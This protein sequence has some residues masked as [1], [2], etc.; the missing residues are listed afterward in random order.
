MSEPGR[1]DLITRAGRRSLAG[2]EI[3]YAFEVMA[4]RPSRVTIQ[5]FMTCLI[6]LAILLWAGRDVG[7]DVARRWVA[8]RRQAARHAREAT[9]LSPSAAQSGWFRDRVADHNCMAWRYRRALWLPWEFYSLGESIP[10]GD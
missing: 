4:M 10:P 2:A 8:C 9:R 7:P 6:I 1:D 5:R 3:D